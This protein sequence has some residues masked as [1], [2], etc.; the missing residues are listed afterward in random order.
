MGG[1]GVCHVLAGFERGK[2]E[3]LGVLAIVDANDSPCGD[4]PF[5][6]RVSTRQR[7]TLTTSGLTFYV[8]EESYSCSQVKAPK[9]GVYAS[10]ADL[11]RCSNWK[12]RSDAIRPN[13]LFLSPTDSG[14]VNDL[15]PPLTLS[16]HP[17][18]TLFTDR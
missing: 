16:S 17:T 15:S 5:P 10:R 11:R 12:V 7:K 6:R 4:P 8:Y 9:T 14:N 2:N 1:M 13:D 3:R 18:H